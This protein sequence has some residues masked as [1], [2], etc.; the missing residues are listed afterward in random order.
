ML[1]QRNKC[2][3]FAEHNCTCTLSRHADILCYY[4]L[5][6]VPLNLLVVIIWCYVMYLLLMNYMN[7]ILK[8]FS[9]YFAVSK[10]LNLFQCYCRCCECMLFAK[11]ITYA[12]IY[13]TIVCLTSLVI[14]IVLCNA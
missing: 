2:V 14:I 12:D 1:L 11:H 3:L 10:T 9:I 13:V 4:L 6:N 8:N 7:Y 5:L